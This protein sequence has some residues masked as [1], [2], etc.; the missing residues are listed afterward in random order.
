MR[1]KTFL[2]VFLVI[3]LIALVFIS[4]LLAGVG[5]D[6]FLVY[7]AATRLTVKGEDPYDPVALE[8]LMQDTRPEREQGFAWNLPWLLLLLAPLGYLPFDFAVRLWLLLNILLSII[9]LSLSWRLVGCWEDRV[10]LLVTVGAGLCF[11]GTLSAIHI[12]Q[13]TVLVLFGVVLA[14]WFL[15]LG[16]EL[17]AG[18]ALLLTTI[19]PHLTYLL[20][21]LVCMWSLRH[22]RWKIIGGLLIAT[23][24]A[25]LISWLV[26][27]SW[28]TSYFGLVGGMPLFIYSTTTLGGLAKAIWGT[29]LLRFAALLLL[30][31]IFPLMRLVDTHGW[32]VA[33]NLVLLISLPLA[34]HGFV[35]DQV[36]FLPAIAQLVAWLR[37]GTLNRCVIWIVV[38]SFLLMNGVF[39]WL[40]TLPGLPYHYFVWVP[41]A[42]LGLYLFV[43]RNQGGLKTMVES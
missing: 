19:K 5:E 27:P 20:L 30:P 15:K 26:L 35:F 34:P 39:F 41:F 4:P 6:D 22:R 31:L 12:G 16:Q 42:F 8:S 11:G 23:F 13:V 17:P 2:L 33:A 3:L 7:W 37:S 36:L 9:A 14:L 40:L 29:D 38:G 43:W 25:L 1:I 10:G 24:A 18:A 21:L 28:I 32:P